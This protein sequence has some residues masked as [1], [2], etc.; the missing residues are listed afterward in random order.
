VTAPIYLREARLVNELLELL[1]QAVAPIAWDELVDRFGQGR[2]WKTVENVFYDLIAF[3]AV[4]KVGGRP[5]RHHK[6]LR[7]T[8]LGSSWLKG[9]S[10]PLVGG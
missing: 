5:G 1:D 6:A 8:E 7:I 2:H 3:G 9:V 4:Q 10:P